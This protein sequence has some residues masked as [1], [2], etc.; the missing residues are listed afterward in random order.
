MLVCSVLENEKE[1]I[2]KIFLAF[3]NTNTDR[4]YLDKEFETLSKLDGFLDDL[5]KDWVSY[6]ITMVIKR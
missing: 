5:Y 2:M 4:V 6:G 1:N 3:V